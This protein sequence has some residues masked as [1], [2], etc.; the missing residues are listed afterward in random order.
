MRLIIEYFLT[1]HFLANFLFLFVVVGGT[2]AAYDIRKEEL[3]DFAF[4]WVSI[5]TNYPGASPQEVEQAITLPMEFEMAGLE[6]IRRMDSSSKRGVSR[7]SLQLR[8]EVPNKELALAEINNRIL[9]VDLPD[10]V[11]NP[12]RVRHFKTSQKAIIDIMLYFEDKPYLSPGDRR[13]LQHQV[14]LLENRLLGRDEIH[15]LTRASYF[16][17]EIHV[18]PRPEDLLSNRIGLRDLR[19]GLIAAH[20]D[21][22]LGS[23]ETVS[24]EQVRLDGRLEVPDR[25]PEVA[26]RSAFAGPPLRVSDLADVKYAFADS[27]NFIRTN[28]HESV[29][30]QVVKSSSTG[31][32]EGIRVTEEELEE[33]LATRKDAPTLRADLLDDESYDV[34]NRLA[35]ITSN[36]LLGFILISIVLSIFLHPRTAFW[37]CMGIPFSFFFTLI[38]GHLLGYT[39][40]NMTLAAAII[41]MGMLVDDAIVVSES[42]MRLRESGMDLARAT[43]EGTMRV[44]GPITASITTTIVAFLPL[45]VYEGERAMVATSI[46]PVVILVLIGSLL[47]SIFILPGHL[48]LDPF[49]F[50]RRIIGGKPSAF[51]E[52]EGP[53]RGAWFRKVEDWYVARL[54]LWLGYRQRIFGAFGAFVA[55]AVLLFVFLM[56]FSLFPREQLQNFFVIAEAPPETRLYDTARLAEPIEAMVLP[57]VGDT[58]IGVRNQVGYRRYRPAGQENVTS[59]RVELDEDRIS[60][61][62]ARQL[63]REVEEKVKQVEGFSKIRVSAKRG[64]GG[65][66]GSEIEILVQ[67]DNDARRDRTAETLAER[68]RAHKD[69]GYVEI[70][71]PASNAEYLLHPRRELI[72]Q[73]NVDMDEAQA[74]LRA[75]L[76]GLRLY[77]F[78][79]DNEEKHVRLRLDR[80]TRNDIDL[81]LEVPATNREGYQVP[82]KKIFEVERRAS[83]AEIQRVNRRR[84]LRVNA[85]IKPESNATPLE[86]AEDLERDIFPPILNQSPTT[87]MVF[88]GEV[89]ET[90]ETSSFFV[91]AI[92]GVLVLIYFI[93]TLQFDSISKPLIVMTAIVP[94]WASVVYVFLLHGNTVFGLFTVVG[95]LGLSGIVVNSSIL[96]LD[97]LRP[98]L[99]TGATPEE[100]RESIARQSA[101]RLRAVFLTTVTTVAGLLPTAYGV[102]GYDALLADMMLTLSWGLV[103]SMSVTLVLV[104]AI[105]ASRM[106]RERD[107]V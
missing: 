94:A 58:V 75:A 30:L 86:V 103:F 71:R 74:T 41:A 99:V 1:R 79:E 17:E 27:L 77:S 65:G 91:W 15:S 46:P 92:L 32:L 80:A 70:D 98:E 57:L 9:T 8:R 2:F 106:E 72:S 33:F 3:P 38:A 85:D 100:L 45:L 68:L 25:F 83:I 84:V 93:L 54:T 64:W 39:I 12:P 26:L 40:N 107:L 78:Y 95:A 43:L 56:N 47:E 87:T 36:A 81:L 44:L 19:R 101:T 28:G 50:A 76:S 29:A 48:S 35:I 63:V 52:G 96:L 20:S 102:L 90:R 23:M 24:R 89:R 10:V 11:E 49:G 37:V 13:R 22:P 97:R 7:V 62:A 82:L 6:H 34:R 61:S 104:P 105:V 42:I 18:I 59:V 31:I 60:P 55:G 51:F 66:S 4:D 16:A 69:I 67:E 5:T 14:R 88:D 21:L 73:L 53:A